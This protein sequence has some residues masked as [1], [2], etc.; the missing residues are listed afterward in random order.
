[1]L[2]QISIY[3]RNRMEQKRVLKSRVKE[4]QTGKVLIF[5]VVMQ[6]AN[7]FSKPTKLIII[8]IIKRVKTA[9]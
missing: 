8:L 6:I 5:L 9:N 3:K 2:D 1:M 7:G 4:F